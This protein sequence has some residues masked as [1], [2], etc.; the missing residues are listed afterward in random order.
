MTEFESDPQ[1]RP[2]PTDAEPSH[3]TAELPRDE[4]VQSDSPTTPVPVVSTTAD[5][6]T[7]PV[8]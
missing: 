7:T 1:R 5:A 4:R 8:T 6:D 3:P 2:A